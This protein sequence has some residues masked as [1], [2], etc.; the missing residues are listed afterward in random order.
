MQFNNNFITVSGTMKAACELVEQMKGVV[1]EGL[2]IVE[3]KALN[4]REKVSSNVHSL[5]EY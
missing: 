5:V 3:L 2:V 1:I 4:G